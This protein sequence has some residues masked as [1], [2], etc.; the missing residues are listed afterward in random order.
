MKNNILKYIFFFLPLLFSLPS[1]KDD[2]LNI[3]SGK[4]ENPSN[5]D[6]FYLSFTVTLDKMGTRVSG[7][8]NPNEDFENYIDPQKFRVLF[9]D[10]DDKF[11]F[12]S[13]SRWVKLMETTSGEN[14]TWFVSVPFF[15]SGND[16]EYNWEWGK[17]R[18]VL[19][20]GDFKIAILAN[21]PLN[22]WYPGFKNAGIEDAQWIDNSG[23]HW[24]MRNSSVYEGADKM[25]K[26]VFDLHHCQ[27]DPLYHGK[28]ESLGYYDFIMGD[29]DGK[30]WNMAW[31]STNYSSWRPYMG[32]TSSWVE[33]GVKDD[34]SNKVWGDCRKL[35]TADKNYPIP[36]Y[37]IQRFK[38]INADDWPVGTTF[39]LERDSDKPI[40]M[41]RSVVKLELII[42]KGT[43]DKNQV[44]FVAIQY[45]NVY[46]RCEPMNNWD[47]TDEVW[48][49][50]ASEH[51][52]LCDMEHIRDHGLIAHWD[53]NQTDPDQ[54]ILTTKLEYQKR[55][56][57][58]YGAWLDKGWEFKS[59]DSQNADITPNG[60]NYPQI[61]NACIQRNS[62]VYA[63][64]QSD[65]DDIPNYHHYIV[66]LGERNMNDPSHLEA[67]DNYKSGEPTLLY[68]RFNRGN[69]Q[70]GL[71][72]TDYSNSNN[73]A[74]DIKAY[75][76]NGYQYNQRPGTQPETNTNVNG[77]ASG[78][79]G[80]RQLIEGYSQKILKE[81]SKEN[82][83]LPLIR[84]HVYTLRVESAT[85]TR[86]KETTN[87]EFNITLDHSYSPEI[88]FPNAIIRNSPQTK[89]VTQPATLK[90]N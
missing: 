26:D 76:Y 19:L 34:G 24:D 61:Y 70:Y 89:N 13:K 27:Y 57:W 64:P 32:A 33:W 1:C 21:R 52:A 68:W 28:A 60:G 51:D 54:K 39:N 85:N 15:S 36:M 47:P 43:N 16:T 44:T 81:T 30:A 10:S 75:Q 2:D 8:P 56:S 17:I 71:P 78:S 11:L 58:F 6:E 65:H 23:P 77:S 50:N 74:Y 82:W 4:T 90:E 31:T 12:E 86:S 22:E 3:D 14:S 46:S 83:P 72:I 63:T 42:P 45:P 67:I 20:S 88:Y 29:T 66:Y 53:D 79:T 38:A 80:N 40:S 25:V 84:N 87:R 62:Y 18:S 35:K 9:F 7:V 49:H 59:F 55:I 37:G 5:Q 69:Q 73:P 41:L 48:G